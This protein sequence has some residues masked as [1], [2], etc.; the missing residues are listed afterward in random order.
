MCSTLSPFAE[1]LVGSRVAATYKRAGR[2]KTLMLFE[3]SAHAARRDSRG[4]MVPYILVTRMDPS[5]EGNVQLLRADC[6]IP[7]SAVIEPAEKFAP[8]DVT[9]LWV[10]M[11]GSSGSFGP[12]EEID[13]ADTELIEYAKAMGSQPLAD[14]IV[15]PDAVSAKAEPAKAKAKKSKKA[16]GT[17]SIV[18]QPVAEA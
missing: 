18:A 17:A 12:L 14:F 10:N 2:D 1:N 16:R 7:S 3:V 8:V 13:P 5:V 15:V 11:T 6:F 4:I 9:N